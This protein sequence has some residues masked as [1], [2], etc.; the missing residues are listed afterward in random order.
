MMYIQFPLI[1]VHMILYSHKILE[2]IHPIYN[3]IQVNIFHIHH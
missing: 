1:Q 3:D 2:K